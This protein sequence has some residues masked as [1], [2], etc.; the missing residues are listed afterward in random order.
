MRLEKGL[1]IEALKLTPLEQLAD[2]CP[3]CYGPAVFGKTVDE[4]D[5]VVCLD[6]N[7]QHQRHVAASV[8]PSSSQLHYPPHFIVPEELA[9]WKEHLEV[10]RSSGT[11]RAPVTVNSDVGI[12]TGD[13]FIVSIVIIQSESI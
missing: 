1:R 7:F 5:C 13:E 6:G 2:N 11:G 9:V 12:Q 4:P 10:L 3:H 8:E